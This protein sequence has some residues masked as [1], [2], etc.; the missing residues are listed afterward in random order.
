[1][2]LRRLSVLGVLLACGPVD[3]PAAT[4]EV[5]TDAEYDGTG[6][7]RVDLY[8]IEH[9][10][11]VRTRCNPQTPIHDHATCADDREAA[12]FN[13]IYQPMT[14]EFGGR[15]AEFEQLARDFTSKLA[16]TEAK[17]L[18]LMNA[19]GLP[20]VDGTAAL[21][22]EL[23]GK[24]TELAKVDVRVR[25]LADQVAR[26]EAQ[27]NQSGDPDLQAQ[28]LVLRKSWGDAVGVQREL[29]SEIRILK[30]K[31]ITLNAN[32]I[33]GDLFSGLN[34]RR[35]DLIQKRAAAVY[36]ANSQLNSRI[37]LDRCF[38]FIADQTFVWE[39]I[40]GSTTELPD[41]SYVVFKSLGHTFSA[42]QHNHG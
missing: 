11:L 39:N 22:K 33:D 26:V 14:V 34:A 30:G 42:W 9:G 10:M 35:L 4:R 7:E 8:F 29:E 37:L 12:P 13:D 32:L 2:V 38:K 40:F 17:L 6:I 3:E 1:M 23:N 21:E 31:I 16:T 15:L 41:G 5:A 20:P 27:L 36:N 19:S 18:E 25:A 24:E 28:L